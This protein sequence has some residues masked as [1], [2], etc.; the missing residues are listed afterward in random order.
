MNEHEQVDEIVDD[1][2]DSV[3]YAA[4]DIERRKVN[5]RDVEFR[6]VTVG[7]LEVRESDDG[8]MTFSGYAAVFA[9]PSEP[10]PFTETI[11][12]GAFKRSLQSGREVRMFRNHNTDDVLGSTR[13]GTLRLSEDA[14]GLSVQADLPDTSVGRDLAVLMRR[15]DVHSM[16]FGFSV[17]RGG[18]AWSDDG[19]TRELREVI[20]HEVSVVTGFPAYTATTAAVRSD[21]PAHSEQDAPADEQTGLPV[22]LARRFN[23]LYARKA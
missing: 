8:G 5:G 17:P 13:A 11:R 19:Q 21:E 9:S 15:G 3:R 2:H 16:S 7:P 22:A 14:R 12:S 10:L 23:D 6:T 1:Q 20:L 18:D 4:I